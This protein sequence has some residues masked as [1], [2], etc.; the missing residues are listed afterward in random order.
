MQFLLM[1]S[2]HN[3]RDLFPRPTPTC[4]RFSS[5]HPLR[6]AAQN[7]ALSFPSRHIVH[8]FFPL[9]GVFSSNGGRGSRPKSTQSARSVSLGHFVVPRRPAGVE[10]FS[11]SGGPSSSAEVR[12]VVVHDIKEVEGERQ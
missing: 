4:E 3:V 2:L 7:F 12:V 5:S 6:W 9:L 1:Q 8:S 10:E 11:L